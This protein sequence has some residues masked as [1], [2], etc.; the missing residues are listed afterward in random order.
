MRS[1]AVQTSFDVYPVTGEVSN[2]PQL[3]KKHK[4]LTIQHRFKQYWNHTLRT[5]QNPISSISNRRGCWRRMLQHN[6]ASYKINPSLYLENQGFVTPVSSSLF[7]LNQ[8]KF[9]HSFY[10]PPMPISNKPEKAVTMSCPQAWPVDIAPLSGTAVYR[11]NTLKSNTH[12]GSMIPLSNGNN[13]APS[14]QLFN[15]VPIHQM[16]NVQTPQSYH[17]ASLTQSYNTYTRHLVTP[18]T[19]Q[20]TPA[21]YSLAP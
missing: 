15:S 13:T 7:F 17:T 6:R 5:D 8:A 1:L 16:Q 9:S 21:L 10:G 14:Y 2:G 3:G 12:I 4:K 11:E 18:G 20:T 19:S